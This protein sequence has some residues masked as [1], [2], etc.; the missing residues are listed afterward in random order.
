M[1]VHGERPMSLTTPLGPDVLILVGFAGQEGISQLFRY[2]LDLVS[3]EST[4]AFD[5]LLGQKVSVK[6]KTSNGG[7]RY[8]SGV[9]SRFSQAERSMTLTRFSMEVVP[10]LWFLTRKVQSRIFQHITVP[11]ILKK[12]FEGIDASW[13]LMGT[14]EQRDY[15]AQY[16]ESDFH[17]ASRL[18][19]EEGIYYYF[20]HSESGHKLVVAN[21]PQSHP[22]LEG[23]DII[24]EELLGGGRDET[25]VWRWEKTQELRPG[26][27]TLWDHCFELPGKHL[28]ADKTVQES[29]ALG[30]TTHKLKV[31]GNDSFEVYDYPGGYAQRFDGVDKSGGDRPAD[32]QKIFQD[33]KRTVEIRMQAEATPALV[34]QG[35][36]NV[37]EFIPGI[38]FGLT[39]HFSDG[40]KYVLTSVEHRA[41]QPLASERGAGSPFEYENRFTCIPFA[42]PF[43]PPRI[44]PIP[45]VRGTQTATVVGPSGEEIFT[46][47]YGRVKVQF[48]WDREGKSDADSAC[49][50]RVA[51]PWAGKSYGMVH[52]PRIGQEVIVDFLEGDPDRPII[53]GSVYNAEQMPPYALPDN[54][55]Q[56]G[57]KS[58]SSKGG[59]GSNEIRLEDKKGTEQVYIHAQYNMDSVVENDQTMLV[60]GNDTETV[61]KDQT[62]TIHGNQTETVDKDRT[63][64]IHQGDTLT[65][66]KD[67]SITIMGGRTEKVLKDES[68]SIMGGRT[69]T[70]LK[71]E[72]I[73]ITGSETKTVVKSITLTVGPQGLTI[74]CAGALTV[75]ALQG[76][77]ITSAVPLSI[78][79]PMISLTTAM[80]QVAGVVQ[81]T[82]V[83]SPTYTPGAG[84]MI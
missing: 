75:T 47:K 82:S 28:E 7:T 46:D 55:T 56:S 52:I 36:G 39:R 58:N 8:F 72:T 44:T 25:R 37:E 2:Q 12:V 6:W 78:T 1:F 9:V 64:T 54:K 62:I 53:V 30:R 63:T 19:E 33:N 21:T 48:H 26:K 27:V 5:A 65:V 41:Q 70:V 32:V 38:K 15:C 17:F 34:I 23:G 51:S 77:T 43:R 45:T 57:I 69:E 74:T 83:V 84:N 20:T 73:T 80:L 22:D 50:V 35:A 79:S 24:Y 42:L 18:M 3:A 71:D 16:R 76:V 49:W 10:Q 4:V 13:E 59:G 40:G 61:D 11:D 31:G 66:D 68:I 60:H 67:Q 14:F 81:C 29:V